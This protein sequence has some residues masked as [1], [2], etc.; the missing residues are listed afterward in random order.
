MENQPF[1][2]FFSYV[3]N[4]GIKNQ[5]PPQKICQRKFNARYNLYKSH[6]GRCQFHIA[7][8]NFSFRSKPHNSFLCFFS[9]DDALF[10]STIPF[11]PL[12]FYPGFTIRLRNYGFQPLCYNSIL[13]PFLQGVGKNSFS[14]GRL[15]QVHNNKLLCK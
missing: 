1:T 7:T 6:W 4:D 15:A 5:S 9:T 14:S 10:P 13:F 12:L 8:W 3:K 11:C 2:S